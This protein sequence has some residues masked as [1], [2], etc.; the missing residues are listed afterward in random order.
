MRI[1]WPGGLHNIS[2]ESWPSASAIHTHQQFTYD[3][4]SLSI[5]SADHSRNKNMFSSVLGVRSLIEIWCSALGSVDRRPVRDR[6]SRFI[7]A[8]DIPNLFPIE[9][10]SLVAKSSEKG[11][12]AYP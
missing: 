3:V 2:S 11:H 9:I 5:L 7:F 6:N 4:A 1:P 10:Y 8:N 12:P